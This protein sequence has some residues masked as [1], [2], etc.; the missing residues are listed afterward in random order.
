MT[1]IIVIYDLCHMIRM[2][3]SLHLH[4]F[5]IKKYIL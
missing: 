4:K 2:I 5:L 3:Q 1:Y